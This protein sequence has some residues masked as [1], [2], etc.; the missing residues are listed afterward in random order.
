[1]RHPTRGSTPP[2]TLHRL[3]GALVTLAALD[4]CAT[5][6]PAARPADPLAPIAVA[7][8]TPGPAPAPT[9]P[10][11]SPGDVTAPPSADEPP[12]VQEARRRASE[13][14][15]RSCAAG[16][17]AQCH[18]VDLWRR[19]LATDFGLPAAFVQDHVEIQHFEVRNLDAEAIFDVQFHVHVDWVQVWFAESARVRAAGATAFDDDAAVLARLRAAR[20]DHTANGDRLGA[21]RVIPHVATFEAV[22]R[23]A[24]TCG[25]GAA[26]GPT[27]PVDVSED[28]H[29][30]VRATREQSGLPTDFCLVATVDVETGRRLGCAPRLCRIH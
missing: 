19:H 17:A 16:D 30:V 24:A 14:P 3:A 18:W 26:M 7:P 4:G 11:T 20:G 9:P 25:P 2:R 10:P 5:A 29:L 28:G 6:A 23:A 21:L 13:D 1:M 27:P 12:S 15:T 8:S 22:T